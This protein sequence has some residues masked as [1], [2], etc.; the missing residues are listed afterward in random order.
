MSRSCGKE[1]KILVVLAALLLSR[2]SDAW[3]TLTPTCHRAR[4]AYSKLWLSSSKIHQEINQNSSPTKIHKLDL[5]DEAVP[6]LQKRLQ[7]EEGME[8]E[9]ERELVQVEGYLTSLRQFGPSFCFL[10]ISRRGVAVPVQAMLKRQDFGDAARFDGCMKSLVPGVRIRV[11]GPVGPTRNKG[12]AL[13]LINDIRIQ[14]LPH[15]PQHVRKLLRLVS[16]GVLEAK[17]LTVATNKT[18]VELIEAIQLAET[19]LKPG[20]PKMF[21]GLAKVILADL[22]EDHNNDLEYPDLSS[23]HKLSLSLP[24]APP[25]IRLAP[26]MSIKSMQPFESEKSDR[27]S[28]AETT[29]SIQEALLEYGEYSDTSDDGET[30]HVITGWV[31]NRRRF[32]GSITALEVVDE[33]VPVG[34]SE[35]DS[36]YDSNGEL[37]GKTADP[38]LADSPKQRLKCIL[39]PDLFQSSNN[40]TLPEFYGHLLAPGCQIRMT[41]SIVRPLQVNYDASVEE[42]PIFWIQ[43]I[44]LVSASWRPSIV[45]YLL[46]EVVEGNFNAGEAAQSLKLSNLE[47]HRIV[48][49]DD[50]TKRQWEGTEIA[51]RLQQQA[52]DGLHVDPDAIKTLES[53]EG[54]RTR[55]PLTFVDAVEPDISRSEFVSTQGSRWKRKKEPQLEWMTEQ[56][57]G[58]LNESYHHRFHDGNDGS[59]VKPLRILDVGGGKGFLANHLARRLLDSGYRVEILVLDVSEG[60]VHNGRLRSE[61]RNLSHVVQYEVTD[62]STVDL[63]Q[64]GD[65]DLVVALH[66]CGALTDVALGH[67]VNQQASFVICPCCFLSNPQLLVPSATT[68]TPQGGDESASTK[69]GIPAQEWLDVDVTP[70]EK[71]K[72]LAE[73]QGDINLANRAIHTLC[74]LRLAAVQTHAHQEHASHSIHVAIRTFPVAFSTRNFCLVGTT[75]PS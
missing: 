75:S 40:A 37:E 54:L 26:L 55:F 29:V 74:A 34:T 48:S 22:E 13:V 7:A 1:L 36:N 16:E 62:A 58:V 43:T 8:G 57:K 38:T 41:G 25:S 46:D 6:E 10:D 69:G 72:G 42:I 18:K 68:T 66:A 24:E 5:D 15:N 63:S 39:H 67:A 4:G 51:R 53:F 56:V 19:K 2:V 33:M 61:R 32:K 14:K 17:D 47:M 73:I 12:E 28:V 3:H 60:A 30:A 59:N 70:Y 50:L 65:V 31:Q 20:H 35:D 71:I 52:M 23:D 27:E 21:N 49:I 64:Y 45:Q 44:S 9:E 11:A